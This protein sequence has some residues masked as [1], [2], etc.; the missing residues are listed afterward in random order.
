M[1]AINFIHRLVVL[2]L[3]CG[4]T[5]K[6]LFNLMR[7][8][9]TRNRLTKNLEF[10]YLGIELWIWEWEDF[11]I[12]IKFWCVVCVSICTCKKGEE[13]YPFHKNNVDRVI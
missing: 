8:F 11:L 7:S 12:L 9:I 3:Y 4:A 6:Q 5:N 1:G 2:L 10:V 13:A